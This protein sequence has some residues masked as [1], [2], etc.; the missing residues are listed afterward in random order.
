[1]STLRLLAACGALVL[2]GCASGADSWVE[3][4]GQR[5]TV[6]VADDDEER[7]MGLM[8]REE[9]PEGSGMIFIHERQEPQSYWMKN[10]KIPLDILYFDDSRK[11]VSQQR[12]VPP[13]SAGNQC[14]PYPS[15][16][17]AR[18]VLE[19]NAGQAAKLKLN[20]GAVLTFGPGLPPKP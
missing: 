18:Y 19:L 15:N 3:L 4:G 16:A 20:D 12:D 14:P 10:T 9:M 13:C 8:F 6:E 5:Y 17:P 7:A 11:L 1:M 2:S